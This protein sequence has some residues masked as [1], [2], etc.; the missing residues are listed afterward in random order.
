MG[1][2]KCDLIANVNPAIRWMYKKYTELC[3][4]ESW[5]WMTFGFWF[6]YLLN[7]MKSWL[8]SVFDQHKYNWVWTFCDIGFGFDG[9]QISHL[10]NQPFDI[11]NKAYIHYKGWIISGI[12]LRMPHK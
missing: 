12:D 2:V 5:M 3:N 4:H 1:S 9:Q 6:I 11:Y 10:S 7:V 8:N